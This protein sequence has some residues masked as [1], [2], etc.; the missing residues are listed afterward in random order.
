M[1]R[2]LVKRIITSFSLT[3]IFE[4][5]ALAM[6]KPEVDLREVFSNADVIVVGRVASLVITDKMIRRTR[7]ILPPGRD[8]LLEPSDKIIFQAK[9]KREYEFYLRQATLTVEQVIKG[10]PGNKEVVV[11]Y[12]GAKKGQGVSGGLVTM[13]E[14]LN[15]GKRMVLF[16]RAP[17]KDAEYYTFVNDYKSA[18]RIADTPEI[19]QMLEGKVPKGNIEEYIA[20]L[21]AISLEN[22]SGGPFLYGMD[23]L[24]NLSGKEAAPAIKN[25]LDHTKDPFNRGQALITLFNIGDYARFDEAMDYISSADESALNISALKGILSSRI[26][27]IKD[28]NL[29]A[30]Y[31]VPLMQHPKDFVRRDAAYAI[32]HA[33]LRSAVPQMIK[34]LEDSD[35]DTRY[36]C[37][38]GLGETV[39][40]PAGIAKELFKKNESEYISKWK[41]WWDTKGHLEFNKELGKINA[42][43]VAITNKNSTVESTSRSSTNVFA[44]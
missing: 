26:A 38:M 4:C 10:Q 35:L 32:R 44:K 29:V 17:K 31:C 37:L 5:S 9:H 22:F 12:P 6:G 20:S 19:N 25:I 3:L 24:A 13:L 27:L 34:G 42:V 16:L 11:E 2:K 18:I 7:V 23:D 40:G 43:S 36:Q 30:K 21:L 33:H 8:L 1:S 15:P 14:N 39:G 28:T 41:T